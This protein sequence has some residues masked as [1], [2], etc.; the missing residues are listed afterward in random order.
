MLLS[1]ALPPCCTLQ[2]GALLLD[3]AYR[4]FSKHRTLSA[5]TK[6]RTVQMHGG[7]TR[8]DAIKTMLAQR[9]AAAEKRQVGGCLGSCRTLRAMSS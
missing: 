1:Q 9:Q 8:E 5:A 3:Q 2:T 6:Q 4:D 7:E